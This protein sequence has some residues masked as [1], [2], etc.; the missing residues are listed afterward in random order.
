MAGTHFIGPNLLSYNPPVA[1]GPSYVTTDLLQY[2]DPFA[3]TISGTSVGSTVSDLSGNGFDATIIVQSL[4]ATV[5]GFE[6]NQSSAGKLNLLN[7]NNLDTTSGLTFEVWFRNNDSNPQSNEVEFMGYLDRADNRPLVLVGNK[8]STENNVVFGSTRG[9]SGTDTEI[10]S[11][12]DLSANYGVWNQWV[13]TI[14]S[15]NGTT[16][17]R[18]A[19]VE[20][21]SGNY[22]TNA[23]VANQFIT[24]GG[25]VGWDGS[26]FK[27]NRG[28]D[29]AYLGLIRIYQK[30]LSEAEATQNYDA[31]KA[32]YGL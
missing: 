32:D 4:S 27:Y 20:I 25:G 18:N 19:S 13:L 6:L 5:N 15:S 24:A 28:Y 9:T 10:K 2:I 8:R 11:S 3:S 29:N 23:N 14:G 30:E 1:A 7:T 26:S 22:V 21:S 17:Y 16:L 31:N 12:Y